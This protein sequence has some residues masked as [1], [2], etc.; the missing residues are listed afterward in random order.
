MTKNLTLN[1]G[2]RWD[3]SSPF[4]DHHDRMSNF[5]MEP[6]PDFN[7]L[8]LAGSRG[9]SI[10]DRALVK[11]YKT[12]FAPRFG[13]AWR[14]PHKTVVRTS[15]GIFNSGTTL[16]GINGRL[17]FNPPF[18]ESVLVHRRSGESDVHAGAGLPARRAAADYQ[19]GEPRGDQLRS[20]YA[21]RIHGAVDVRGRL[22]RVPGDDLGDLLAA[23]LK[24]L[25]AVPR[26]RRRLRVVEHHC[27]SATRSFVAHWSCSLPHF[28]P[29]TFTVLMGQRAWLRA[30]P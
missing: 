24:L 25:G 7:K 9:D 19:P 4:W 10:A 20:K 2:L 26:W 21:Q 13:L 1:L 14:L 16:F 23:P 11:F 29:R 8:V 6:G 3:L 15:Y 27:V 22:G 28:T 17:S 5:I 18:N 30:P 12:D